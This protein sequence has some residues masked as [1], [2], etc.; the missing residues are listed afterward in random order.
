[1]AQPTENRTMD[2]L[3]YRLNWPMGQFSKNPTYR[4]LINLLTFTDF[5][6]T[7]TATAT[8]TAKD[9]DINHQLI[10]SLRKGYGGHYDTSR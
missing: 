4:I 6:T 5:S 7:A 1:M 8:P 9:S 3:V 2:I 10:V